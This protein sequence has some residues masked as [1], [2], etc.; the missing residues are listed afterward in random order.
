M[1]A[2]MAHQNYLT[3]DQSLNVGYPGKGV[4]LVRQLFTAEVISE[5]T[6][7]WTCPLIV[8]SIWGHEAFTEGESE[9]CIL[10]PTMFP[11]SVITSF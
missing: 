11:H 9:Q 6:A 5:D 10:T 4:T 8:D 7:S 1:E 3:L 2:K